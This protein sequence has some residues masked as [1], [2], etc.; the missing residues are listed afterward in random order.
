M[1]KTEISSTLEQ[2]F[3]KFNVKVG[4]EGKIDRPEQCVNHMMTTAVAAL[5]A[6]F[7]L[8]GISENNQGGDVAQVC[9][10][11]A[12]IGEIK[13]YTEIGIDAN[14]DISN[15]TL[16]TILLEVVVPRILETAGLYLGDNQLQTNPPAPLAAQ[17]HQQA[18]NGLDATLGLQQDG[19]S[20]S[21]SE[22]REPMSAGQQQ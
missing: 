19:R 8:K 13:V 1:S 20:T 3:G 12:E 6:E 11:S 10:A 16:N 4:A 18:L 5:G 9:K 21:F 14:R 2:T 22:Y 15:R 7:V 17:P